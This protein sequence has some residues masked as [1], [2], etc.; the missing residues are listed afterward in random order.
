MEEKKRGEERSKGT[1]E[2]RKRIQEGY[3]FCS[4]TSFLIEGGTRGIWFAF[5]DRSVRLVR[6]S[7]S[8]GNAL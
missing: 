1:G 3:S 7:I 6:C 8:V 5:N 2:G 4:K